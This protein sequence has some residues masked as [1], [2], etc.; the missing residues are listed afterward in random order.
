LGVSDANGGSPGPRWAIGVLLLLCA[1]G[2]R[3]VGAQ[4]GGSGE[5]QIKAAFLFH[6]GEFVEWPAETF[7][8]VNSPITYCTIGEDPFRGAL[9]ESLRAKAIGGHRARIQHLKNLDGVANCQVLFIGA[10]ESKRDNSIVAK[11]KGNGVLTVGESQ[12]FAEDGGMIEFCREGN[13]IRFEINLGA[14][15]AAK[16]KMSAR[17]LALAKTVIGKAGGD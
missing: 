13:K 1:M 3:S 8:D 16:L 9:D 4:D 10:A 17:L 15:S 12:G 14:V 5:Y 2:V 6:F 11:G 7:K